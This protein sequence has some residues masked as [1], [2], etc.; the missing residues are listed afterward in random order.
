MSSHCGGQDFQG[1]LPGGEVDD[2]VAAVDDALQI[3]CYGDAQG[4][5]GHSHR[6]QIFPDIVS[7]FWTKAGHKLQIFS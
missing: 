4:A 7:S 5:S 2:R 1:Y 6:A 3:V